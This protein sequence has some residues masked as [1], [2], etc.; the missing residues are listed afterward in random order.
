M[1]SR[2]PSASIRKLDRMGIV[3]LRSTTLCVAVSS[4]TS[5]WRLTVISIAAPCVA[6]FSTSVSTIGIAP[7]SI[8]LPSHPAP[9]Q[10]RPQFTS[11]CAIYAVAPLGPSLHY[12]LDG[13]KPLLFL[14][15]DCMHLD[16]TWCV[17]NQCT[18]LDSDAAIAESH[19]SVSLGWIIDLNVRRTRF[20]R[21]RPLRP[22]RPVPGSARCSHFF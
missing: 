19:D 14:A 10:S 8:R 18:S 20:L 13:E 11:T 5:S 3:V 4:F 22:P 6:G 12:T 1:F 21:L 2:S 7:H 16:K 15:F 9:W 17:E